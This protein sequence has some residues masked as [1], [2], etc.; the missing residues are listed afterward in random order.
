MRKSAALELSRILVT[1][2]S[3]VNGTQLRINVRM[4][5]F[6]SSLAQVVRALQ[7]APGLI[8]ILIILTIQIPA[9]RNAISY[10]DLIVPRNK[11]TAIGLRWTTSALKNAIR[12]AEINASLIKIVSGERV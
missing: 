2:L 8:S 3:I 1:T 12:K 10:P 9:K 6:G 5:A 11:I 7:I 4:G